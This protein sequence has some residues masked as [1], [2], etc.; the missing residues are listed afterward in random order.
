MNAIHRS[1]VSGATSMDMPQRRP[2]FMQRHLS[3]LGAMVIG[4]FSVLSSLPA[5]SAVAISQAPLYVGNDVP[6]NLALVPSVE[7]PTIHSQANIGAYDLGRS[8]MG[9]FDPGKCYEYVWSATESERHFTPIAL[10]N[11]RTCVGANRWSGN[12]LSWAATQTID[13]FR[14]ALTGGYR[15]KDT[16]TTTWLEKARHAPGFGLYPNRT[17]PETGDNSTLV[18]GAT[19]AAWS[20][21]KVRIAG[22]NNKMYFTRDGNLDTP[23]TAVVAYNPADHALTDTIVNGVRPDGLPVYEVSMR[24]EVCNA[25]VGLES[26]CKR[27]SQGYKP[28]GLIQEYSDRLRYSI[29]G[30]LNDSSWNRDGGVMRARQKFV[31]PLLNYPDEDPVANN[32]AEWD[33]ATGVLYENPDATDASNTGGGVR[34]SGVINYLNRFGQMTNNNPKS[35]D[36]VSELYYTAVRYFKNQGNVSAYSDMV[37]DIYGLAD[38]FPVITTWDDPIKYS[39]QAN[40]ILGIGDVYTHRDKNLPG[41]DTPTDGEPGKPTAVTDD[42]TVDVVRATQKVFDLEG[43][44]TLTNPFTGRQNSAYIAGLAYDSHTRD[45]RPDDAEL[46]QTEGMQTISTHWVDVRENQV[47]EPRARN[48]YWLAAKYGGFRVPNGFDPYTRTEALDNAWWHNTTDY[49]T[50][51]ANGGVTTTPNTY[52]RADNF[53]VASEA[54]KMVSSLRKAFENIMDEIRGSGGSFASNTT[55]LET[56]AMTYQAQFYSQSWRGELVAYAVNSTTG[57]LT[58][59]WVASAQFPKDANGNIDWAARDIH[60]NSGGTMRQFRHSNLTGSQSTAL[61]SQQVVDYLRGQRSNEQPAGSLRTRQSILGDI[62]NSQPVYVG[63][64][65]GRLFYGTE[66]TGSSTYGA[67]VTAQV[68]RKPVIYVGANDGMLH[69][70]DARTGEETFAF[71]PSAAVTNLREYTSPDY[72]HRYYVDGDITVADAYINNAWRS[73]LVGTMGRGGRAVYALDVTDPDN[74]T[75]LWEKSATDIPA[76]GNVLGKPIIAQVANGDWRV[77]IGNGPNGTGDSAQLIMVGLGN[78]TVTTVNTGAGT[79]NGMTAVNVWNT[80]VSDFADTVY[81][82]DLRGNLWKITNL[83]STPTATALFQAQYSGIEQPISAT[84][85]V[86]KH[87]SSGQTWVFFGTGQYL[88]RDDLSSKA[89]Q[90]WY[91]IIDRGSPI[92]GRTGL[93]QIAIT[94]EADL[95]NGFRARV[96]DESSAPGVNGWYMD[97]LTGGS[98]AEGERMVVPNIFQGL[99]LIGTTRI[100][101]TEDVCDPSGRGFV[102]AINPFTGGRLPQSFF[103]TNG[104]GAFNSSDLINGNAASG[105]GLPSGPNNPIF[106]GDVMLTNMDNAQG[107]V[108]KTN[109]SVLLPTRVSW[110]EVVAD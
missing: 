12:F 25:S 8:Y 88:S 68:S 37:G 32:N 81:A 15:V 33:P 42:T 18:D 36:P 60:V 27:Y 22:L 47:L 14:L 54:D 94:A 11:N 87:P 5:D 57:A 70:F 91:G 69:G 102:M 40:V 35:L 103:D 56:G 66:F 44:G 49:L 29:F 45:I 16:S 73:I 6:G 89:V 77:F 96:I 1:T 99:T 21:F 53:Y 43:L 30:Y 46:P 92:S 100:P 83:A 79:N 93:K 110:R 9:Y 4:A 48:Q 104:D 65:N 76:L 84:P 105:L 38:G 97:L 10:T 13:P 59:S 71:I 108:I 39:C 85:M 61:G 101:D 109:S 31:G 28:E 52:R 80:G 63:A 3:K 41:A 23:A 2:S 95:G 26:N 74:I 64:P 78:G 7:Y 72:V 82:G 34:N 98:T 58:Q 55:K 50:S 24:V 106:I 51:G 62:V 20:I 75:F 17:I 19:P 107:H 90:T 86:S 67:F